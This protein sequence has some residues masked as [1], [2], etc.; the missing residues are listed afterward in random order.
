MRVCKG[1]PLK[2]PCIYISPTS[3]LSLLYRLL[4]NMITTKDTNERGSSM[5]KVPCY[6][7]HSEQTM[8]ISPSPTTPV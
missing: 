7:A 8:D 5:H 2:F 1:Y 3:K 4:K 6:N